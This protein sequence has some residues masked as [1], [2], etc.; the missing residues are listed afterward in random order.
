MYKSP[1]KRKEQ[2][3]EWLKKNNIDYIDNLPMVEGS[4]QVKLKDTNEIAKRAI[5]NMIAIQAA[6]TINNGGKF[7]EIKK[8]LLED[9]EKF[10]VKNAL[11][12]QEKKVLDGKATSKEVVNV[13]WQYE[14]YWVLVWALGLIDSLDFPSDICDSR[15]ATELVMYSEDF[16][17]F[18]SK[19]KIRDIEE[20]LDEV[21]KYYRYHWA[22][23][24]KNAVNPDTS[25]GKLD[26]EVVY[27][28]R[29]G[30]EW[31]I[32]DNNEWDNISL[33]T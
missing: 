1:A 23:V 7:E 28:R 17:D 30:L 12:P 5:A 11:T 24:D 31:L 16:N 29:R 26:P 13:T 15:K 33:D 2:S 22:C 21:D 25:I 32:S 14:S 19:T 4:N 27:E 10:E 9:L 20:I 18:I 8:F 6:C 3:I